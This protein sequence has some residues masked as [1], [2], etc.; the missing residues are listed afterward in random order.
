MTNWELGNDILFKL[1]DNMND[2][3]QE[4]SPEQGDIK[5]VLEHLALDLGPLVNRL[6]DDRS[7]GCPERDDKD[8]FKYITHKTIKFKASP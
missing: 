6:M 1:V 3:A 4:C 8:A 5:Y 7:V 2:I